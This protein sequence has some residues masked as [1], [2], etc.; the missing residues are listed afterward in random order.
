MAG[1]RPIRRHTPRRFVWPCRALDR[2]S[3]RRVDLAAV[4]AAAPP[5]HHGHVVALRSAVCSR[6]TAIPNVRS[7]L[8]RPKSGG[9]TSVIHTR[10]RLAPRRRRRPSPSLSSSRVDRLSLPLAPGSCVAL[11]HRLAGF[12]RVTNASR[13]AEVSS[14]HLVSRGSRQ[15][16]G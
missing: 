10:V 8:R 7:R 14:L 5:P 11:H 15:C 4:A 9:R 6:P 3:L 16:H 1:A 13:K 12:D 2:R